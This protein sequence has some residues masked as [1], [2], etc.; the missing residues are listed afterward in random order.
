[1]SRGRIQDDMFKA[2][3]A[4]R[5]AAITDCTTVEQAREAAQTGVARLPWHLVGTA[6]EQDLATS[7]LTVRCLQ[8]DDGSLPDTD[9]ESGA[10][11]YV[12]RAY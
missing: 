7:G 10:L 4:R 5:D 11:A 3:T 1:M 6:G 2:A 9:D 12:A 8:L